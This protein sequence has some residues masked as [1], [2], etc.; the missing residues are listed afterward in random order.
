MEEE[1]SPSP[2]VKNKVQVERG[3]LNPSRE[4]PLSHI[5]SL[6]CM[7]TYSR[8]CPEN[9]HRQG[10]DNRRDVR[11]L[12]HQHWQTERNKVTNFCWIPFICVTI[13]KREE[14]I[15]DFCFVFWFLYFE[16]TFLENGRTVYESDYL[17]MNYNKCRDMRKT[18]YLIYLIFLQKRILD[19]Y[20]SIRA[21]MYL[22]MF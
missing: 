18:I 12:F 14:R 20:C 15:S 7:I 4:H 17:Q 3:M 2:C 13:N 22:N 9:R 11:T 5:V 6:K 8:L 1:W 21:Y 10:L 19:I 16:A